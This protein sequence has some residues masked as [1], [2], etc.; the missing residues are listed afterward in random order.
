[1]RRVRNGEI[2]ARTA[3]ALRLRV[4]RHVSREYMVIYLGAHV[5]ERA[6]DLLEK[7]TLRAYDSVQL[8]SALEA[9]QH[10]ITAGLPS[11]IFVSADN[12]LLTAATAEGFAV[13][14]PNAHS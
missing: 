7:H 8:A 3:H 9:N 11:L 1:M 12:Q 13:D 10:V 4:G 14:N 2:P 5:I 6:Q